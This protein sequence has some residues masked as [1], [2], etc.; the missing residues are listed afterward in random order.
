[1]ESSVQKRCEPVIAHPEEGH[2]NDLRM[3]HLPCEGRLR[4][5]GLFSLEKAPGR[6]NSSLS[7]SKGEAVRKKW[8]DS[9][10]KSVVTEQ[11]EMVSN[12]KRGDLDWI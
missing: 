10:A 2:K 6:P 1:M 9:L 8:T 11:R 12:E 3:E 5:L 7:G 4:E